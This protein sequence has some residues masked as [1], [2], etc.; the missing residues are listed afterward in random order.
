MASSTNNRSKAFS[1]NLYIPPLSRS[2]SNGPP[3]SRDYPAARSDWSL[4]SYISSPSRASF[5]SAR[6]PPLPAPSH[7]KQEQPVLPI[8]LSEDGLDPS[9]KMKL[10]RKTR[11]LSRILGEVPIPVTVSSPSPATPDFRFLGVLEEPSLT[12]ASTSA[13]SSPVKTPPPGIDHQG[14]LKRSATVGHNRHAQQSAI[15]RARS[16]ASMRPSLTIPP[17]ALTVHAS[18]I[19]PVSFSWPELNPIPPSPVSPVAPEGEYASERA[20]SKRSSTVSSR[21]GSVASSIFPSQ[22]SPEQVLRARAAKLARQLGDNIPPEVLMRAA[23]PPPPRT[24]MSSPPV[25]TLTEASLTIRQP[26]RRTLSSRP[27][28]DG[29]RDLKRRLSLDLRAFI[30]VPAPPIPSPSLSDTED[31]STML[32]KSKHGWKGIGKWVPQAFRSD[33]A[34]P[35]ESSPHVAAPDV[36]V[37]S[38]LDSDSDDDFPG[39]RARER[40]RALNLRRARKMLQVFGNEPPPS[41]FQITNIPADATSGISAA[42][43]MTHRRSDSHATTVSLPV[44]TLSVPETH[45]TRHSLSTVSSGDNLSPLIFADPASV[46]P[47]QPQ[48]PHSR[49]EEA[50]GAPLSTP[51][52]APSQRTVVEVCP[53]SPLSVATLASLSRQSLSVA[54]TISA[55]ASQAPSAQDHSPLPSPVRKSF[56][57][58][59]PATQSLFMWGSA[60]SPVSAPTSPPVMSPSVPPESPTTMYPSDPHFR[61]R[62]IRA[63]KLSRFFGVGLNDIAGMLRPGS[64]PPPTSAVEPTSPTALSPPTAFRE[65]RRSESDDSIP[66]PTSPVGSTHPPASLRASSRRS[67]RP[68]TSAGIVGTPSVPIGDVPRERKRTMSSGARSQSVSRGPRRPQTQP[69]LQSGERSR[70]N[71]QPEVLTQQQMHNRAFSTTVEVSSESAK[72]PFGFFDGRRSGKE[73]ELDMHDVIRALRKMK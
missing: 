27:S 13:S 7:L 28:R 62:R 60:T 36:A 50:Q 51:R 15:H 33:D 45:H 31:Y 72:R 53:S 52:L 34:E 41:L 1:L 3:S 38:D 54:S 25:M 4:Q 21:R 2:I 5:L 47:S 73:K 67:T 59:P 64:V 70:S 26:P 23:S 42:A 46:P 40:Q 66:S 58:S 17:A 35:E 18:P 55:P 44:S 56:Q 22:R 61:V 37:D 65:F 6:G 49:P 30:R 24:P 9:E 12:S 48:S 19:S 69:P 11:K 68:V 32:S 20:H 57:A 14:S 71:S 16:L 63:A 10:L 43:G 29:K 8:P 39:S